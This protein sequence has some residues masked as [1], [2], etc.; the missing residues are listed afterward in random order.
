VV[1]AGSP[2]AVNAESSL[3]F[4]QATQTGGTATFAY[5]WNFGDGTNQTGSLNP[6]HT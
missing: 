1:N 6:S 3:T 2:V 5:T 4:S